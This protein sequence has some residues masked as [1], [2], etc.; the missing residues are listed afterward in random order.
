MMT[1]LSLLLLLSL[2]FFHYNLISFFNSVYVLN[3]AADKMTIPIFGVWSNGFQIYH[4]CFWKDAWIIL[5]YSHTSC[6][7]FIV[8]LTWFI[9]CYDQES[10]HFSLCIQFFFVSL[11]Y[12]RVKHERMERDRHTHTKHKC[13]LLKSSDEWWLLFSSNMDYVW[14]VAPYWQRYHTESIIPVIS[15]TA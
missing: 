10:G 12:K 7:Y 11:E 1:T 2:L 8:K 6:K 9:R 4:L 13:F 15:H 3:I 14:T 5:F